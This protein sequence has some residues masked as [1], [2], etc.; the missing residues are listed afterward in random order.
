[1]IREILIATFLFLGYEI[2]AQVAGLDAFGQT[3]F[4][5]VGVN[6]CG[7][8]G[9]SSA[10]LSLLGV[11]P[12]GP[13][14]NNDANG[15]G[16]IADPGFDGWN[17]GSPAL[18]GDAFVPGSPE[19]SWAVQIG[20][21]TVYKNASLT[22]AGSAIPGSITDYQDTG[23]ELL[24]TWEGE[25]LTGAFH[26]GIKQIT[27]IPKNELYFITEVSLTNLGISILN[28]VYYARSVD[29]DQEQPFS[30]NFTTSNTVLRQGGPLGDAVASAVGLD[31][32]CF[33][34]LGA[35]NPNARAAIGVSGSTF[36]L[37]SPAEVW[38]G[39]AGYDTA[40]NA[41]ITQDWAIALAF[42]T[43][44][45]MPG[46]SVTNAFFYTI[47]ESGLDVAAAATQTVAA[48][49][50]PCSTS[51]D[52]L[53]RRYTAADRFNDVVLVEEQ[54]YLL[55]GRVPGAVGMHAQRVDC[56][57]TV[58][59]SRSFT[60]AGAQNDATGAVDRGDGT[61]WVAGGLSPAGQ[62]LPDGT[63]LSL[64]AATGAELDRLQLGG[65]A[66]DFFTSISATADDG[67]VLAGSWN[68]FG[69]E[70]AWLVRLSATGDTVWSRVVD[71]GQEERFSDA[72]E[73]GGSY[74]A[75]GR[76]RIPILGGVLSQG[77]MARYDA[78]G[79]QIWRKNGLDSVE[80]FDMAAQVGG[81]F[82]AAGQKRYGGGDIVLAAAAFDANGNV[83]WSKE[84]GL[85][86]EVSFAGSIAAVSGGYILAG[87]RESS[88]EAWL[89]RL[90]LAGNVLDEQFVR[91]TPT[92][93]NIF[94]EVVPMPD[95]QRFAVSGFAGVTPSAV[96]GW[97]WVGRLDCMIAGFDPLLDE[98]YLCRD[99]AVTLDA[100]SGYVSYSWSTGAVGST[101]NVMDT[102]IYSVMVVDSLG[103]VGVDSVL[104]RL[105]D[106]RIEQSDTTICAGETISLSLTG[107]GVF[108]CGDPITD[109]EGNVYRTVQIGDQCWMKDNLRTEYYND[110][111][112]IL[113]GLNLD[114][115]RSTMNGAFA[116]YNESGENESKY[117]LLY[118]WYA[119]D[120][121]RGIC[122]QGW[123]VGSDDDWLS[124]VRFIDPSILGI[125]T[126][127][128]SLTAGLPLKADSTSIPSWD[129]TN[130]SGFSA[131]PGGYRN[132]G[133]FFGDYSDLGTNGYWWSSTAAYTHYSWGWLIYGAGGTV[134]RNENSRR[135]GFSVR[136][137]R[138]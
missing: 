54:G 31:F 75:V 91:H 2:A 123:H 60:A 53:S 62:S 1:M 103:C 130:A 109:V 68:S 138:D 117:G 134:G 19:E 74:F 36:T 9:G 110:G 21:G 59:W 122:P 115:W 101:I 86:G 132:S 41:T 121:S 92:G 84:Y 26:L 98:E 66:A 107:A 97:L 129:G 79:N 111:S 38:N 17:V 137:I 63:V 56:G 135:N 10:N 127:G 4:V 78:S 70:D 16:F 90:D 43:P 133:E 15:L 114:T 88:G 34:G 102:G 20:N 71:A 120:D 12:L 87:R 8:Y 45:L 23:S 18:C 125:A 32:G 52:T 27:R 72:L 96:Q 24:I 69:G 64:D 65:T 39:L 51:A 29:P 3:P 73:I 77:L 76:R 30:G 49:V 89:L 106:V 47:D 22:C 28:N 44:A 105:L 112:P 136:C 33:L 82:V 35:R 5:E 116:L 46:E 119:I 11:G 113:T 7:V 128:I 40:L 94:T 13:W 25:L 124:L 50:S 48:P 37:T 99:G 85:R 55:S 14:N 93:A 67:A 80:W 6:Q 95:G 57:G 42:R 131:L 100:G 104:V 61:Y 58:L 126:G 81:G 83:I 118:N 108:R